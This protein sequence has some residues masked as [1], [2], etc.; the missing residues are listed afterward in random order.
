M[1][2]LAKL[3]RTEMIWKQPKFGV[4]H[5]ELRAGDDIYGELYWTKWFSDKAVGICNGKL[6]TFDREGFFRSKV[7]VE[8]G[9]NGLEVAHFEFD[10]T[11]GGV[12]R[13]ANRI[14][15][16]WYRTKLLRNTWVLENMNGVVLFEMEI[17][18]RWFK[19]EAWIGLHTVVDE[20]TRL[21][22]LLPLCLYLAICAM[23]DTALAVSA[24]TAAY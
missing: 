11:K 6:W 24:T 13:L 20:K 8:A 2:S 15:Y 1:K 21:D 4:D 16:Q 10:W 19:Q 23:L 7:V 9:S 5:Y 3:K 12:I 18:L 14:P 17:G 22:L